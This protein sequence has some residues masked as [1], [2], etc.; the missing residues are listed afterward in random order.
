M[1][2]PTLMRHQQAVYVQTKLIRWC[3]RQIN[4]P[5]AFANALLSTNNC[6]NVRF[7]WEKER[8]IQTGWPFY[9]RIRRWYGIR[10]HPRIQPARAFRGWRATLRSNPWKMTR[11]LSRITMNFLW[12]VFSWQHW[13]NTPSMTTPEQRQ[14]SQIHLRL[15]RQ[16]LLR[17]GHDLSFAYFLTLVKG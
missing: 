15:F 1:K 2:K 10:F 9:L 7:D 12:C 4:E 13:D 8:A 6:E 11:W 16:S 3:A 14:C 5:D 17:R